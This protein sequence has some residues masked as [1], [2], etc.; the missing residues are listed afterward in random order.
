[1]RRI[2]LLLTVVFIWV[3]ATLALAGTSF[4]QGVG[5]CFSE[6]EK[7]DGGA[8]GPGSAVSFTATSLADI[9]Q[10]DEAAKGVGI[11]QRARPCPPAP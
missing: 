9:Q 7:T 2:G 8:P 3:A 4:A 1:M 10:T 6:T 11:A 5:S